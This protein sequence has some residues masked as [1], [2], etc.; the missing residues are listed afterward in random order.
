MFKLISHDENKPSICTKYQRTSTKSGCLSRVL[1]LESAPLL[2]ITFYTVFI[3]N[4]TLLTGVDCVTTFT[5]STLE[6]YKVLTVSLKVCRSKRSKRW[7][8]LH[9]SIFL[10]SKVSDF[11]IHL[12]RSVVITGSFYFEQST[13]PWCRLSTYL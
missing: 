3:Q 2:H 6:I 10:K 11:R 1:K 7:S 5:W 12:D 9:R 4:S 13:I 8:V